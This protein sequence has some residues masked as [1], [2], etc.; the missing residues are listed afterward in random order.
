MDN[1]I[2]DEEILK[3]LNNMS[4]D[5]LEKIQAKI[6]EVVKEIESL[7]EGDSNE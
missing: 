5:E 6:K 7:K 1:N 4:A 2:I 3:E